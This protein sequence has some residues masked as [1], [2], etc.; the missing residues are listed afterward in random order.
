MKFL[1]DFT[2]LTTSGWKTHSME[3]EATDSTKAE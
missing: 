1:V 2:Y 3:V